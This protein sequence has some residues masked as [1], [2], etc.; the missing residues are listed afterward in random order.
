MASQD[1]AGVE[2]VSGG[3]T[4]VQT[5]GEKDGMHP[6]QLDQMDLGWSGGRTYLDYTYG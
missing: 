5:T 1:V 6:P 3:R 2:I 4:Y